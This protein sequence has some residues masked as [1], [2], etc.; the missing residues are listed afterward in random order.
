MPACYRSWRRHKKLHALAQVDESEQRQLHRMFYRR[1]E[2]Y[3]CCCRLWYSTSY[4]SVCQ[5]FCLLPHAWFWSNKNGRHLSSECEIL[6]FSLWSFHWYV[7]SVTW[8]HALNIC[9]SSGCYFSI[10]KN[11]Y[12]LFYFC[13]RVGRGEAVFLSQYCF[14]FRWRRSI[15]NGSWRSFNV[16]ISL[17][18]LRILSIRCCVHGKS[19]WTIC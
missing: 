17:R 6:R 4:H 5:Y 1:T 11:I 13:V 12:T 3:R 2:S 18:L 14:A 16:P 19:C 10:I 9:L 8:L 7:G 15:S